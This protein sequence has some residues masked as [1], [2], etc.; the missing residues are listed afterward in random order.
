MEKILFFKT[1]SFSGINASLL[2]QLQAQFGGNEVMVIDTMSDWVRPSRALRIA[3]GGWALAEFLP[4]ILH[5]QRSLTE[6]YLRSGRLE[7]RFRE[8]AAAAA[9]AAAAATGSVAFSFASQSLFDLSIPGIPHFVFTDHT[10]L[11]NL[12]YPA[13][14]R[15]Q[16]LPQTAIE[17]EKK[18]YAHAGRVFVMGSHVK[19]SLEEHY[20]LPPEKVTVCGGGLNS[21]LLPPLD[22]LGFSNCR[23]AFVGIDWERKGGKV[24]LDAFPIVKAKF[25][26]AVL[27]IIGCSPRNL[28][29]G[30]VAHGLVPKSEVMNLLA[31]ASIFV[32]PSLIEPFGI[33]PLEAAS[34]GLPVVASAI[35]ALP[36]TVRDR[37]S[38]ILV[39]PNDSKAL[40][41][42]LL[43]LLENPDTAQRM[44]AS[45][46]RHALAHFTWNRAGELMATGIR[47]VLP[48][49]PAQSQ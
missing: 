26:G 7:C 14:D 23:I 21:T 29:Q 13:F 35:G 11:A 47:S 2:A 12:Y 16:L 25:P 45:G 10:H 31:R 46:R 40:A 30:A 44:G 8:L 5:R 4:L 22:N 39:P 1:G 48:G 49:S 42:A 9:A 20:H 18:I 41:K 6:V 17:R 19:R 34:M 43:S 24:L 15:K 3:A 28:P 27:D 37:D 32:F 38:G 36:E 33:A